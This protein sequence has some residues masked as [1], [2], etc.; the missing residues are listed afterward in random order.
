MTLLFLRLQVTALVCGLALSGAAWAQDMFAPRLYVNDRVITEFEVM[1][2]AMFLEVLGGP[3]DPEEEALKSLV[4]DRLRQ[5]EAERLGLSVGT[6]ELVSGMNEFASRANLTAEQLVAELEKVGISGET[7]RDFVIAGILWRHAVRAKFAGMISVSENEIDQALVAATREQALQVLVSE[8]VIPANDD[9][10]KAAALDLARRLSAEISGEGA[11]AAAAGRHSASPSAGRGG[12]LDWMPLSN[13]PAAIGG[14]ILA[15]APGEVSDPVVVPGAVVLFMLRDVAVDQRAEPV[16][17][18]VEWA[19]FLVPDDAGEIADIR[20]RVDTCYDL[21]REAKGLP[22][23]RLTMTTQPA[24]EVPA[25][26][27]LELA[28]LDVGESSVALT[29]SGFRRLIMLCSREPTQEEPID[30]ALVGEQLINR[31]IEIMA[32]GYMQELRSA[33]VIR[34][35]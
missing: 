25:D 17:V 11:F 31:K 29:R 5:V 4:E 27:G 10:Q 22:E 30:R 21:N 19:E 6:D 32:E 20:A 8:L 18:T 16:A 34:E 12:R 7:Y 23:D 3:G 24:T 9:A 15:L 35:P 13:L 2:R 28:R 1:Q 33:A 26:V 14:A